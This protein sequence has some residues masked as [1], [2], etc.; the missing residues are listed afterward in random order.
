MAPGRSRPRRDALRAAVAAEPT[1]ADAHEAL[2]AVLKARRDWSGAPRPCAG[3]SSCGPM[4]GRALHARAGAAASGDQAGARAQLDD[5]ER[6]RAGRS[7][8]GG[9]C[10]RRSASRN[11]RPATRPAPSSRSGAPIGGFDAYAPAHYQMGRLLQRL[12]DHDAAA[13]GVRASAELNPS[14]VPPISPDGAIRLR[15]FSLSRRGSAV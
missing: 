14:L 12:G 1:Y 11:S 9:A 6:L 2:G 4:A 7:P 13:R 3:R 8:A 5:A 10:G 15:Q